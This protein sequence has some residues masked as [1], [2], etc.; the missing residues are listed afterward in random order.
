MKGLCK[1]TW[2]EFKLFF[3][4]PQAAFF[5]LAFPLM[6]LF[7][8][9]SIY[10]NKPTPFF[11]GYGSVD[12][13]VPSYTALIIATSGLLSITMIMSIYREQGILRRFRVTPIRPITIL[14]SQVMVIF[15]MTALGL[16]LLVIAGKA[17]YGLRF[18]GD[19]LNLLAAFFLSCL[20]FFSLG[21]VLASILPT[22]RT[23]QVVTMTVYFPMIFLSGSTIPTEVL[24]QGVKNFAQI[25]PLTH[26]VN[27]LRGLW[28]G[29]SL[30]EF[31][32]EILILVSILVLG[33]FISSKTFR[34]E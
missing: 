1:L 12:V 33:I 29:Q 2:T 30:T 4:E 24:P 18:R 11:N 20:S 27:L 34:W 31:Y 25:I 17:V 19:P 23:T 9:G 15:L 5:T 28:T 6:M 26:V 22:V 13:S 7:L 32:K 14:Y 8:F 10:G 16:L 3:R 21:I